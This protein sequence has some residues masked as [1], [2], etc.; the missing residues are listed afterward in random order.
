[1]IKFFKKLKS[2]VK[3]SVDVKMKVRRA[4]SYPVL[5]AY[6]GIFA[7]L[8]FPIISF[9]PFSPIL[10]ISTHFLVWAML[11]FFI[12]KWEVS[13]KLIIEFNNKFVIGE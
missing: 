6:F 3:T 7:A 2:N 10:K 1:M 11:I 4:G 12:L 5:L 13:K 9:I 8:F